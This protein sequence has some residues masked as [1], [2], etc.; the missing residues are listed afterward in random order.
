MK[1]Q[2]GKGG[3]PKLRNPLSS[4]LSAGNIAALAFLHIQDQFNPVR[5]AQ[6]VVNAEKIVAHRMLAD[7]E[8]HGDVFIL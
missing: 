2:A 4:G 1:I 7:A 3:A 8:S 5:D 6:F